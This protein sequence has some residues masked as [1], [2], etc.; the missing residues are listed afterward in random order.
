MNDFHVEPMKI[1]A[2]SGGNSELHAECSKLHVTSGDL[3]T[4]ITTTADPNVRN[5][6]LD[7]PLHVTCSAK[8]ARILIRRGADPNAKNRVRKFGRTFSDERRC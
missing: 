7:T 8:V 3:E 6:D 2:G 5:D 1:V 4:L